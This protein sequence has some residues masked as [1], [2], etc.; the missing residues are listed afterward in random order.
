MAFWKTKKTEPPV[1][2]LNGTIEGKEEESSKTSL[3]AKD[4]KDVITQVAKQRRGAEEKIV[5]TKQVITFEL[6]K[7][8]Y[9]RAF[10]GTYF[11]QYRLEYCWY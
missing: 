3:R 2:P 10:Y 7:W 4:A 1:V 5:E 11:Y 8:K 9:R 6:D